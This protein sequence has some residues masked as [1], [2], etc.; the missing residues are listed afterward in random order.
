MPGFIYQMILATS[1][2]NAVSEMVGFLIDGLAP[3]LI[4]DSE[5]VEDIPTARL[6]TY[7]MMQG[8]MTAFKSTHREEPLLRGLANMRNRFINNALVGI[9]SMRF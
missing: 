1:V 2:V 5:Y 3:S 6:L 8:A 4:F 7:G 9:K